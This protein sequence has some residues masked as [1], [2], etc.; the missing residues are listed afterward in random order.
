[1][2]GFAHSLVVCSTLL[3]KAGGAERGQ[4]RAPPG[5]VLP[6]QD[7]LVVDKLAAL[8]ADDLAPKMLVLQQIEKV[9]THG[10]LEVFRV[11]RLLPVQQIL[12]VVYEG[13][14]FEVSSLG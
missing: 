13:S 10:K 8:C 14:I 11:L 9:Q 3:L 2:D 5:V 1:M 12:Q 7:R 6:Q 4:P